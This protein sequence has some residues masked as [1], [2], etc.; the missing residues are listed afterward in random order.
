MI[1]WATDRYHLWWLKHSDLKCGPLLYWLE[2][3]PAE[4]ED[5]GSVF[6]MFSFSISSVELR[7]T[8]RAIFKLFGVSS[9]RKQKC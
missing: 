9:L 8:P 6:K 2:Q 1:L 4:Q 5:Q 3:L 7:K